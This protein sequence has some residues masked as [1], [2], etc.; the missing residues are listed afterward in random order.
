MRKKLGFI[1]VLVTLQLSFV[2]IYGQDSQKL[3]RGTVVDASRK[4]VAEAIVYYRSDF[5]SIAKNCVISKIHTTKSDGDGTFEFRSESIKEGTIWTSVGLEND[6]YTPLE[7][8]NFMPDV[9]GKQGSRFSLSKYNVT[10]LGE[11]PLNFI[12]SELNLHLDKNNFTNFDDNSWIRVRQSNG[13]IVAEEQFYGEVDS[14]KNNMTFFLPSG[15]WIIEIK[16]EN[17][18]WFRVPGIVSLSTNQKR[19]NINFKSASANSLEFLIGKTSYFTIDQAKMRLKELGYKI[20]PRHFEESLLK[21]NVEAVV[22]LTKLGMNPNLRS[23]RGL[24]PLMIASPYPEII[25]ILLDSGADINAKAVSPNNREVKPNPRTIS[26][27]GGNA[28]IFAVLAR[29]IESVKILLEHGIAVNEP[30]INND[31][32]LR[33][34]VGNSDVEMTR[35]LLEYKANPNLKDRDGKT[36]LEIALELRNKKIIDLVAANKN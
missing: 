18:K 7:P 15:K 31:T 22:L 36:S 6:L 21:G 11:V 5:C 12:Y 26:L 16:D 27:E 33:F 28:L 34:A 4:P 17:R 1:I 35:L 30:T 25:K 10:E 23:D 3:I 32:A 29:N 9:T 2:S 13:D 14:E 19:L 20:T 24:T 8:T